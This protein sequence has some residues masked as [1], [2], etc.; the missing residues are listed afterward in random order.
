[1]TEGLVEAFP[2]F[3][4]YG[5]EF[6]EIVPTPPS[7]RQTTRPWRALHKLSALSCR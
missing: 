1:M 4:P 3:P 6:D 5:G 2:E 7:Q